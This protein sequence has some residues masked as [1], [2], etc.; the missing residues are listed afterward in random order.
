MGRA[1]KTTPWYCCKREGICNPYDQV[2]SDHVHIHVDLG[3]SRNENK[4]KIQQNKT[5]KTSVF[6]SEW[7][8]KKHGF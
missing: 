1:R 8:E 3:V 7:E 6:Y 2:T 5:K 4:N